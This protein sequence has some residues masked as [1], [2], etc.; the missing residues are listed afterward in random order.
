MLACLW[1]AGT[2]SA[3]EVGGDPQVNEL[4]DGTTWK[5]VQ[6]TTA[7][8]WTWSD[9]SLRWLPGGS[10]VRITL[11][12]GRHRDFPPEEVVA[13][14]AA[15]GADL[16]SEIAAARPEGDGSSAYRQSPAPQPG[17]LA[18]PDPE[19]RL[20]APSLF[21]FAL[22]LG[23]TYAH[24]EGDWFN[25]FESSPGLQATARLRIDD[26][27]WITLSYIRQSGGSVSFKVLDEGFNEVDATADLGIDEFLL[28]VGL[29]TRPFAAL[30]HIPYAEFGVGLLRH[31]AKTEVP[32][33]QLNQ[34]TANKGAL[35][36][37]LG[38]LVPLG[39]GM[40]LDVGLDLTHKPGL[41][42]DEYGGTIFGVHIG[43]GLITR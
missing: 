16:T 4:P 22:T 34:F 25:G 40:V 33:L 3:Q 9:V 14:Y 8:G 42:I 15:D 5:G 43:L 26:N 28:L 13:V 27:N 32:G 2:A 38:S 18:E 39:R 24:Y 36:A 29:P 20:G 35:L 10:L 31:K 12:D 6:V 17:S 30:G 7:E 37:R 21:D 1:A 19:N 41:V 11:S 23:G